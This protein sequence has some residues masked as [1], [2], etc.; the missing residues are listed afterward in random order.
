MDTPLA[1]SRRVKDNRF[2]SNRTEIGPPTPPAPTADAAQAVA[3]DKEIREFLK[4]EGVAADGVKR[5]LSAIRQKAKELGNDWDTREAVSR[6]VSSYAHAVPSA[7]KE[8]LRGMNL[9][10]RVYLGQKEASR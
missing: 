10:L 1:A 2:W 4:E 9:A 3:D 6:F 7:E 8:Y 5:V